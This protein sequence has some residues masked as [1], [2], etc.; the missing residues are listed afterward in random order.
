MRYTYFQLYSFLV[1]IEDPSKPAN[2]LF[3]QTGYFSVYKG[4][5]QLGVMH[6]EKLFSVM[7][8]E[9]WGEFVNPE[10]DRIELQNNNTS[11][12]SEFRKLPDGLWVLSGTEETPAVTARAARLAAAV[13]AFSA[14]NP[15]EK[16]LF[17]DVISGK[18]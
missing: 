5:S 9:S 17:C 6:P 4:T 8:G 14:L 10:V 16:F 13:G 11:K 7:P 1:A 3:G 12:S 15:Q 2:V 18:K